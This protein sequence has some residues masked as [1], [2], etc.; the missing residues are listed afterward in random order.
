MNTTR[1]K[2]ALV[3]IAVGTANIAASRTAPMP[4]SRVPVNVHRA[5]HAYLWEGSLHVHD[6]E[7]MRRLNGPW[8]VRGD[9]LRI[10]AVGDSY[11][12]GYGVEDAQAWPAVLARLTGYE[13]LNMGVSGYQSEEVRDLVRDVFEPV[14]V[15]AHIGRQTVNLASR[16]WR[17]GQELNPDVIVYAVCLNDLESNHNRW[18]PW[19]YLVDSRVA[20]LRAIPQWIPSFPVE[21]ALYANPTRFSLNVADITAIAAANGVPLYVAVFDNWGI[22]GRI[23]DWRRVAE[24]EIDHATPNRVPFVL[25]SGNWR[26]SRWEGHPNAEAHRRFAAA[27]SEALR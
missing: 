19:W 27:I 8:P 16:H 11:T 17:F 2:V 7:G 18:L 1:V 22:G 4:P 15:Q 10:L 3:A 25:P 14:P 20:L 5:D 13:V 6:S 23:N 26:V 12:Y 24:R 9:R 21:L